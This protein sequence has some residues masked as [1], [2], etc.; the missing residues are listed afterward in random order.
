VH[1]A[2]L[3]PETPADDAGSPDTDAPLFSASSYALP[4]TFAAC[5]GAAGLGLIAPALP[6]H[7][8][9]TGGEIVYRCFMAAYGLLF[10]VYVWAR[11]I[12]RRR[13]PTHAAWI[14]ACVLAMPFY[15]IGSIE[16]EGVWLAPGILIAMVVPMLKRELSDH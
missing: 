10:P 9:L 13:R 14:T 2:R 16:R 7:A 3:V 15:W 4:A 6:D 1:L 5:L 8:G 11:V 12:P